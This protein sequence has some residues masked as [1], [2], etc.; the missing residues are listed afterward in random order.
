MVADDTAVKASL[1]PAGRETSVTVRPPNALPP[2]PSRVPPMVS[3]S[4]GA[5]VSFTARMDSDEGSF[6]STVR[7]GLRDAVRK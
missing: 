2:C 1:V 4:P 3:L 7:P 6:T 5:T